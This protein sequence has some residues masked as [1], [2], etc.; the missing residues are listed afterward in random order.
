MSSSN[1]QTS[2]EVKLRVASAIQKDAGRGIVRI[3]PFVQKKM[4]LKAGD[5]VSISSMGGKRT[6]AKIWP[7]LQDDEEKGTIRMDGSI[8]SNVGVSIDEYVFMRGPIDVKAAQQVIFAPIQARV[9]ISSP[10]TLAHMLEGRVVSRNDVIAVPLMGGG[11]LNLMVVAIKP[12][13]DSVIIERG[14]SVSI[15]DKPASEV[16][17]IPRVSYE[18]VGG[19][20][21][22]IQKI[23]EMVE[24]PIR[25]PELFNHL[26]IEPP[27]GVMLYGPPGT[28]KTLLAKAVASETD[29]YFISIS[30]PEIMSKFYGQSEEK[31]RDLFRDAE[32]KAPSIIFI[33][34][35]DS[36]APKREEVTGE[37]ERRVVAQLLSLMDGLKSRGKVIVIAATNRPNSID[38]ALR[39]PGRFDREIE[40]GVPDYKGRK[41]ILQIH[42]RG[43][44]LE[45]DVD[46]DYLASKTHGFVGADLS[47][48]AK[49]AAMR[50]LRRYLPQIDM[51]KEVPLEL[52]QKMKVTQE[53]FMNAFSEIEPS[54]L[55][56]VLITTPRESWDD[57]GGLE[58]V[59]QELREVAEWPLKYPAVFEYMNATLPKGI[60][61]FGPPGT[62]KTLL[63][64]ALAH[65][66]EANFISV[67]GPEFLS[68]W[69]GE[70]EKAIREVFRK[71]KQAAPAIIFFDELDSIAPVRGQSSDSHVTERMISQFLTE[72]DG[73][74]E[75]R[76][77]LLLAATN[78]PDIIDPALLRA[79]RF[80]RQVFVGMSDVAARK[81][82]LHIHFKGK[83]LGSD[84]DIDAIA[85]QTDG[86]TGADLMALTE[87]ATM[88]AIR[89]AI[90]NGTVT[91]GKTE[92]ESIQQLKVELR[93]VNQALDRTRDTSKRERATYLNKPGAMNP[94]ES[95]YG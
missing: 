81:V 23:R 59:K 61:L 54:A 42:S 48:L 43:I 19:L 69:V 46:I 47:A 78:R 85:A 76:N 73:L 66:T 35:I 87:E 79:G 56:E 49:E 29:A 31:L 11:I 36:I 45:Q 58:G 89:E 37:V 91:D 33:D 40:I 70:S 8:R 80:G 74:E 55:R 65:E 28:G 39:R 6:A 83:P 9:S 27:K 21:D 13:V 57:I 14:T 95:L 25:H 30:G 68:K 32:E 3:D 26:G 94:K 82:I 50:A 93:H 71:A 20:R 7:G 52:L 90:L 34:E 75:L 84:V 67:K 62:G 44:P 1:A 22:E 38:E 41:E 77:V 53:D 17:S 92:N 4:G 88:L 2:N 63:A 24:L 5:V 10:N 51:D 16:S 64:K 86:F 18:D 12:N 60:L 15:S 72:L